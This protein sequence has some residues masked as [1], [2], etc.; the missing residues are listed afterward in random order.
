MW[1]SHADHE[2][3][4]P[5]TLQDQE[6]RRNLGLVNESPSSFPFLSVRDSRV[7]GVR[8]REAMLL[9]SIDS[10]GTSSIYTPA[11]LPQGSRSQ[12]GFSQQ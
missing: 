10:S 9:L 12:R 5:L 3:G 7:A 4:E 6:I 2:Q 11:G 1:S 8:C